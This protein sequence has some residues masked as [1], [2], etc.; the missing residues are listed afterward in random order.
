[1]VWQ[2]GSDVPQFDSGRFGV[3]ESVLLY[4]GENIYAIVE[5]GGKQYRVAPKETIQVDRLGA[6]EGEPVEFDRVLF[7][8]GDKETVVGS[9]VVRGAKVLGTCLGEAKGRKVIAFKYKAKVRYR[10]KK[11]HRQTYTK[12]LVNEIVTGEGE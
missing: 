4:G 5:V 11:G 8:G 1:L 6:A 12:V 7:V 2:S 9:P 3:L 10:R